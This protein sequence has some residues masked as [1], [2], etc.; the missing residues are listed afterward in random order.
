MNKTIKRLFLLGGLSLLVL[1]ACQH[2]GKF[3]A[4]DA[5]RF[6]AATVGTKTEYSGKTYSGFER[7]DWK[8]GDEIRIY[9]DKAKHRYKDQ[10]WADYVII[11]IRESTDR[12]SKADF[13]NVPGDG[14]GNGLVWGDPGDYQFYSVYPNNDN[15]DFSDG[16]FALVMPNIQTRSEKGNLSQ[17]GWMT[18][19]SKTTTTVYGEGEDQKL[20]YDPMFSAFEISIRSAGE[21]TALSQFK[22]ISNDGTPLAGNFKVAYDSN[23]NKTPD[24]SGAS[25]TE[26]VVN[27][28]ASAPAASENK[29]LVFTVLALPQTYK[30][31]SVSFK[32]AQGVTR[33][34]Q[35]KKSGSSIEFGAGTKNRICGLVLPNGEILINVDTAPW[36]AGADHTFTTIEDAST[37]F[38]SYKAYLNGQ[39]LWVDTYVAIAPGYETVHVDP[40]DPSSATTNRPMY[41]PMFNLTTV[42]VGVELKLIS[43]NDKV[44]FVKLEN[45]VFTEP[46]ASLTIPASSITDAFPYGTRNETTYFVVPLEGAADG[47]VAGISLIRTDSNTPVAYTHQDLPGTTD[48]TKV[49]FM[50]VTPEKYQNNTQTMIPSI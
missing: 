47:D 30:D 27:L 38:E 34:L 45:G 35:L 5:V 40:E 44:G 49:R 32:T 46:S 16:T 43:D 1:T 11:N 26:I 6:K 33:T 36:V 18:A 3:G 8:D 13:D 4:S 24:F 39:D 21:E 9:S 19:W 28:N 17:Y 29:D 37:M 42:S 41:S 20:S 48:H 25:D 15:Q 12:Y 23:G 10:N 2:E 22:L 7:I 31:L 14:T 50:V